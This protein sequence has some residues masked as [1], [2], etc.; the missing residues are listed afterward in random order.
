MAGDRTAVELTDLNDDKN[1][2][3]DESDRETTV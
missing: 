1:A 3:I 2:K